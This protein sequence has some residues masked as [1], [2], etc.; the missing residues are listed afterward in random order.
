MSAAAWA[1]AGLLAGL[2][3]LYMARPRFRR[4]TLS[5][6]RFL[7][8]LPVR[9]TRR[10]AWSWSAPLAAPAFWLQ[11]LVLALCLAAV[12]GAAWRATGVAPARLGVWLLVDTSHGMTTR[13]DGADRMAA[14]RREALSAVEAVAARAG[15]A[16]LCF[17][18]S[19]FDVARR[20][21]LGDADAPAAAAALEDLAPRP[22]G[23]DLAVI[24]AALRAPPAD[25]CAVTH[26]VVVTDRPAPDPAAAVPVVWRDVSRPAPNLGLTGI[27]AT[28]DPL[29]GAVE[30]VDVTTGAWGG[31]DATPV[32]AV[33]GPDGAAVAVETGPGPDPSA[34]FVPPAPGTYVVTLA[35]GGAYA[36]DDRAVVQV[37]ATGRLAVDWRLPDSDWPERLGWAEPGA[38]EAPG[39]RVIADPADAGAGGDGAPAVPTLVVGGGWRPGARTTVGFFAEGHPLLDMVNLDALERAGPVAVPLPDGFAPVLLDSRGGALAA[40]RDDPPAALVP[41]LPAAVETGGGSAGAVAATLFFDAL[42]LLVGGSHR[43]IGVAVTTAG[44]TPVVRPEG[45]GETGHVPRSR[46]RI[47]DIAPVPP[48]AG[49][50]P[51]AGPAPDGADG[52]PLWPWLVLA[53]AA[54][55][56]GER[57]LAAARP[58]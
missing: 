12:A 43:P 11:L 41:G 46:G 25:G 51:Q 37:P 17:R 52:R 6:A 38:G 21:L 13:Q 2:V 54:V 40:V 14:A 1:L 42:R 30:A 20:D 55:L 29:T 50:V 18:L 56:A 22:A 44:G 49:P 8:G 47:A 36:G 35:P 53:A 32:V 16:A 23:T 39:L 9:D 10:L 3:A 24:A 45:E 26:A 34:R 15:N 5:A 28:R 58:A 4:R 33:T 19:A 7:A 48:G 27:A 57:A 31:A